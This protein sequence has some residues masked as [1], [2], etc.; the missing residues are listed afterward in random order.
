MP[1]HTPSFHIRLPVALQKR[2]KIAAAE[3]NRSINA[4]LLARIERSFELE[5]T[6]RG[7]AVALLAEAMALLEKGND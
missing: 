4:E 5:A 6:D 1:S 2:L 7:R 3:N